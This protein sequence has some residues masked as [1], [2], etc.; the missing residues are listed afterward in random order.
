MLPTRI[1][2]ALDKWE[3]NWRPKYEQVLRVLET[4]PPRTTD[5]NTNI[6]QRLKPI[7]AAWKGQRVR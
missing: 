2:E 5:W 3:Q 1:R 7:V 6:E 4:L